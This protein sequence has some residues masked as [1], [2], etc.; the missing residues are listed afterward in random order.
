[1]ATNGYVRQSSSAIA[2]SQPVASGPVNNEYNALATAFDGVAGHIHD[3]SAGNGQK[4]QPSSLSGLT[5]LG[6]VVVSSSSGYGA[7][8]TIVQPAAGITMTN[9][10]GI[11]GNPTLALSNDLGAI[12]ALNNLGFPVRTGVDTWAQRGFVQP[13]AGF[14]IANADGVSGNPTFALTNDLAAV[15]GLATTGVAVRT[16]TDT[17]VTVGDRNSV[18]PAT[19]II[20]YPGASAPAGYTLIT[21][22]SLPTLGAG[23]VYIQKN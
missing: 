8:R 14:T 11:A 9:G 1:M 16:A 6:L 4:L 7:C 18:V 23:F 3:G 12:E 21:S 19:G 5:G 13:A 2:P 17:W 15:E 22:A 10:D 20:I